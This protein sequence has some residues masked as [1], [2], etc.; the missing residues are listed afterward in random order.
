MLSLP[1][2]FAI[3]CLCAALACLRNPRNFWGWLLASLLFALAS[4][5]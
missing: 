4:A 2:A 5:A 3:A 1:L